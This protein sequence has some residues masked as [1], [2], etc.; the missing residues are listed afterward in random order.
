MGNKSTTQKI[1]EYESYIEIKKKIA[2]RYE[3]PKEQLEELE[4]LDSE[5]KRLENV[6]EETKKREAKLKRQLKKEKLIALK[7]NILSKITGNKC[8]TKSK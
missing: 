7:N 4:N 6:L 5:V 8:L 2:S 1:V 3:D